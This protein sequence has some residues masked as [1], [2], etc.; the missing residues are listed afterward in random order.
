MRESKRNEAIIIADERGY[1]VLDDGS[2][3]SPFGRILKPRTDTEGYLRFNIK[4]DGEW[5]HVMVHK[6]AAF[7]RFGAIA[8]SEEYEVR[9]EDGNRTNNR[10][11]NVLYGTHSDNMM[12][13]D[14]CIRMHHAYGAAQ[15]LRKLTVKQVREMRALREDGWKLQA[16]ADRY[17]LALST[18]SYIINRRTYDDV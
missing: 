10:K 5:Y 3:L 15:H 7:Q 13:V 17:N 2:V 9:H 18:V 14:A 6:L 12:D 4:D 16:L 11:D 8:L 1:K